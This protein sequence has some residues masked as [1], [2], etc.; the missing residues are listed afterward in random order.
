M[1]SFGMTAI[2]AVRDGLLSKSVTQLHL[3]RRLFQTVTVTG[4]RDLDP[5]WGSPFNLSK[6][7]TEVPSVQLEREGDI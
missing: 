7:I 4:S 2:Q 1:L 5:F 3:Q 6:N